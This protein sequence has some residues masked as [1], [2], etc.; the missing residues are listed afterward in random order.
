MQVS[1]KL[2]ENTEGVWQTRDWKWR[3]RSLKES[4]IWGK[5]LRNLVPLCWDLLPLYFEIHV[6]LSL[7]PPPPFS[8]DTFISF[9]YLTKALMDF[10]SPQP[11]PLSWPSGSPDLIRALILKCDVTDEVYVSNLS[12]SLVA[13]FIH[14]LTLGVSLWFPRTNKI[15][16]Q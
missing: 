12:P 1:L 4:R 7:L 14:I 10:I 16:R 6:L 5:V 8:F 15:W 3:Q 13:Y 2:W 11:S 9:F